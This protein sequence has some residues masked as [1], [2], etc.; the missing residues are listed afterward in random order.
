VA[1]PGRIVFA[2]PPGK[3]GWKYLCIIYHPR[4]GEF[5]LRYG[6]EAGAHGNLEGSRDEVLAHLE[7]HLSDAGPA[8]AKAAETLRNYGRR[9]LETE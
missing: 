6:Q 1:H 7:N 8:V 4:R 9:E 5:S 3:D 2:H